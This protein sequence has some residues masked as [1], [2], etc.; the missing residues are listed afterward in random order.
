MSRFGRD[1][2]SVELPFEYDHPQ[3]LPFDRW[4]VDSTQ[5]ATRFAGTMDG[6]L[7]SLLITR[8]CILLAPQW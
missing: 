6:T 1:M 5:E 4:D 8:P 2:S 3:T 7:A